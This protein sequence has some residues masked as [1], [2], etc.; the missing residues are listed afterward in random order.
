MKK[1]VTTCFL[2]IVAGCVL[3]ANDATVQRAEMKKLDWLLGRWR[4]SGWV[5]SGP[6]KKLAVTGTATVQSK[7]NGLVFLHESNNKISGDGQSGKTNEEAT[8][9]VLCYDSNARNYLMR[10]L[11]DNGSSM[12]LR[13]RY[14]GGAWV[15]EP[16]SK[17]GDLYVRNTCKPD[18]KDAM[19]V[20]GEISE[21]RRNWRKRM[22]FTYQRIK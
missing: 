7:L 2:M 19:V 16:D 10:V 8:F 9:N 12:E 11:G 5:E 3:A 20:V 1:N 14:E 21:D 4:M 6:G 17:Q 13:L 22:E 15:W 18:G